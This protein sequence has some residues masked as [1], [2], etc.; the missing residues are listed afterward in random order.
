MAGHIASPF[1]GLRAPT[2]SGQTT[3]SGGADGSNLLGS[4]LSLCLVDYCIG[5][6]CVSLTRLRVG[7]SPFSLE[8]P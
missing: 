8:P 5:K 2:I 1:G 6:N 4:Q 7:K 3:E